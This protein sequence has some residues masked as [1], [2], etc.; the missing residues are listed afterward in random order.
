MFNKMFSYRGLS[1]Q[2]TGCLCNPLKYS[3]RERAHELRSLLEHI[4]TP[5]YISSTS[6]VRFIDLVP[7]H[8]H[9]PILLLYTDGVDNLVTKKY[10][11]YHHKTRDTAHTMGTLL[12]DCVDYR[13]TKL[14]PNDIEP[15]WDGPNGNRAVELVGHIAGG[16]NLSEMWTILNGEYY[17][18]DTTIICCPLY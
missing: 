1:I 2:I 11:P 18:D 13:I 3:P 4:R 7:L 10:N 17:I 15:G 5:P 14:L 6:S 8:A 12:S 9:Q 16:T